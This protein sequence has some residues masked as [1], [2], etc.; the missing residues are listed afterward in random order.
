MRCH[1]LRRTPP[2]ERQLAQE[3][4]PFFAAASCAQAKG[5]ASPGRRGFRLRT[6]PFT[7]SCLAAEAARPH[8]CFPVSSRPPCLCSSRRRDPLV[9]PPPSP[10]HAGLPKPP[11]SPVFPLCLLLDLPRARARA[12]AFC[13]PHSHHARKAHDSSRSACPAKPLLGGIARRAAHDRIH[14]AG[15]W[16]TKVKNPACGRTGPAASSSPRR[17]RQPGRGAQRPRRHLAGAVASEGRHPPDGGPLPEQRGLRFQVRERIKLCGA[18]KRL[19]RAFGP[20]PPRAYPGGSKVPAHSD[21]D[22]AC[23]RAPPARCQKLKPIK[24]RG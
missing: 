15:T 1:C 4:I 2:P 16:N 9:D 13:S 5:W 3:R 8:A 17:W 7:H 21:C 20:T 6:C 11:P 18:L 10:V 22:C 24:R 19:A 23:L 12:R 14:W